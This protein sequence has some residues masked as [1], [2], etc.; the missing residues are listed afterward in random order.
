MPFQSET[1][2][3]D[4]LRSASRRNFYEQHQRLAVL[5]ILIVF[6]S[7]F[8]GLYVTGLS[9]TVLGMLFSVAAYYLTPYA[10]HKLVA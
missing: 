4:S 9:G 6:L 3:S 7:P 2:L 1:S 8:I 10:W 5:M